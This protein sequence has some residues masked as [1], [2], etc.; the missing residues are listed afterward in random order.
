ME[1]EDYFP[2]K[3]T[4]FEN[5]KKMSAPELV[6]QRFLGFSYLCSEDYE[7]DMNFY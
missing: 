2:A 1:E 4:F 6:P 7:L 3:K 5:Y